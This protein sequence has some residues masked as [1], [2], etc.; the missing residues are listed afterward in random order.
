MGVERR[1]RGST[2][3]NNALKVSPTALSRCRM[4]EWLVALHC[5]IHDTALEQREC[6]RVCT[7]RECSRVEADNWRAAKWQLQRNGNHVNWPQVGWPSCQILS[8][9]PPR[10]CHRHPSKWSIGRAGIHKSCQ[11]AILAECGLKFLL[12]Y[13]CQIQTSMLLP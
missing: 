8:A 6:A 9:P 2:S 1:S 5:K 3:V 7:V 11:I 10:Q 13:V 12:L 4:T